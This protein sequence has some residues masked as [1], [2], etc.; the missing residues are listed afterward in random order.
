MRHH[1]RTGLVSCVL[2]YKIAL[3]YNVNVLRCQ[4][5]MFQLRGRDHAL[6]SD[7][8]LLPGG[9][10]EVAHVVKLVEVNFEPILVVL[11]SLRNTRWLNLLES[12]IV[13]LNC[14]KMLNF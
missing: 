8:D 12:P 6:V 3:F 14:R 13:F 5:V 9:V 4:V 7:D 10:V 2:F 11:D 1:A